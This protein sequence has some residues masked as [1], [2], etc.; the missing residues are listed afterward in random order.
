MKMKKLHLIALT[1]LL[2]VSSMLFAW[3]GFNYVA[4]SEYHSNNNSGIRVDWQAKDEHSVHHYEIYRS[5]SE[6]KI[7]T[8]R[9]EISA[10]GRGAS[11][12]FWDD[13]ILS[14]SSETGNF[15]FDYSIRAVM[16]DG[17]SKNSDKVQVSLTSLG[18]TQQTWGSIKAMF[19]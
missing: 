12:T 11:Y 16:T 5:R 1:V 4:V 9:A 14:K 15:T 10:L 3:D 13:D 7:L 18:V 2:L 6:S 19:R 17:T 8:K